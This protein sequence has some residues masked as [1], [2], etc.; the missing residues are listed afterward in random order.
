MSKKKP[1]SDS[2]AKLKNLMAAKVDT[3]PQLIELMERFFQKA[4]GVDNFA[5]LLF[6]E[7]EEAP[8]GGLIRQR[9]I[10]CMLDA[11][12]FANKI[13]PPK[14]D[15]SLLSDAEL[16]EELTTQM[17]KVN[18]ALQQGGPRQLPEAVGTPG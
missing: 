3:V 7:F 18:N 2:V 13:A 16:E 10:A 1:A 15:T 11:V 9:I 4:G 8:S 5:D 12:K 6:K 14:D 17:S